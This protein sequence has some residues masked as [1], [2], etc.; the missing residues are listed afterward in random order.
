MAVRGFVICKQIVKFLY[1]DSMDLTLLGSIWYGS[2][3]VHTCVG[4]LPGSSGDWLAFGL[5]RLQGG[6]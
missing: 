1:H 3:A 4:F 2:H 6:G 5:S